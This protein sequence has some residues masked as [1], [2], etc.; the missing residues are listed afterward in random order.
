MKNAGMSLAVALLGIGLIMSAIDG[1]DPSANAAMPGDGSGGGY[2]EWTAYQYDNGN[3]GYGASV[4]GPGCGVNGDCATGL[5]LGST[6]VELSGTYEDSGI[7][8]GVSLSMFMDRA[9]FTFTGDMTISGGDFTFPT[10]S[11]FAGGTGTSS[12]RELH[13]Q[14][15]TH[16]EIH[17]AREATI[18]KLVETIE[19]LSQKIESLPECTCDDDLNRDGVVDAADLGLLIGAWGPCK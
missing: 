4:S 5:T 18:T 19:M 12:L 10:G 14:V 8:N 15:Q 11:T 9:G 17:S 2:A 7:P 1:T 3:W 13:A 6:G 16:A